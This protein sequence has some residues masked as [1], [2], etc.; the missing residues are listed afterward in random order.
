MYRKE[1]CLYLVDGHEDV[2]G[3]FNVVQFD[4][5]V[6][7]DEKEIANKLNQYL[8]SSRNCGGNSR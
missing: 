5:Q 2:E 4:E 8:I 6:A 1:Q 3:K 7:E